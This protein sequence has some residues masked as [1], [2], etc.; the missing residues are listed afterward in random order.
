[1]VVSIHCWPY[2]HKQV[3]LTSIKLYGL[4]ELKR[5]DTGQLHISYTG[6]LGLSR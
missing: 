6:H 4:I 5:L 1:M 2:A 3:R